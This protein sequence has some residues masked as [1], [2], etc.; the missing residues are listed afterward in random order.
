VGNQQ[1]RDHLEEQ[2]V[3][4]RVINRLGG[5]GM[6]GGMTQDRENSGIL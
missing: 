2:G 3:D 1:K 5:R 6:D 4:G